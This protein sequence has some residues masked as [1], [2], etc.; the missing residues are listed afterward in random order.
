MLLDLG[1][2]VEVG[3]NTKYYLSG[4]LLL[5]RRTMHTQYEKDCRY[6]GALNGF[7]VNFLTS[8]FLFL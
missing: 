7:K 8:F 5:I 4:N 3:K 2:E 6:T 1:F